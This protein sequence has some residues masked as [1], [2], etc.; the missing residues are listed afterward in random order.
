MR[1]LILILGVLFAS[2]AVGSM[3]IDEGEVVQLTTFDAR[4]HEHE[5]DL[6]IVE[7]DGA[8]YVRADLPGADWLERLR[9][10]PEAELRHNGSEESVRATPV[11]DPAVR[12]AVEQA[13][14]S[15]YG[16]VDRLVGVI[17][18]ESKAITV[19]IEPIAAAPH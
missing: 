3:W 11:D 10:R 9:A 1:Q 19:R 8:R 2:V 15:K 13:M 14:A 18:N 4:D 7:V 12:V 16:L 5:T 17:R 6:W